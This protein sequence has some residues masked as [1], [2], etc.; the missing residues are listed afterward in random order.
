MSKLPRWAA[1]V[2]VALIAAGLIAWELTGLR[3]PEA[4]L[5]E[6]AVI[7]GAAGPFPDTLY[8]EEGAQYRVALTSLDKA[9]PVPQGSGIASSTGAREVMPGQVVWIE[10]AADPS[11][12]G[13]RLGDGG[14]V[15]RVVDSLATV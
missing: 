13:R 1:L 6:V 12:D 4:P 5:R 10:L 14:P 15:V 2:F 3:R 7:L 11:W 9:Y 8:L